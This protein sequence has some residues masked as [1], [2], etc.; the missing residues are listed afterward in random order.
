MS[1]LKRARGGGWKGIV[2]MM[3]MAA[4]GGLCVNVG[5]DLV[6]V[7]VSAK[8]LGSWVVAIL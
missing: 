7:F 4:L 3:M 1:S 6:Q 5:T 8:Y 2:L